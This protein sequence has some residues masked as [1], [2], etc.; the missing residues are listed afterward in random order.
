MSVSWT[1]LRHVFPANFFI[2]PANSP[3]DDDEEEE[4][5]SVLRI[6]LLQRMGSRSFAT[7][8][9]S[10]M[11]DW[12]A[13]TLCKRECTDADIAVTRTGLATAADGTSAISATILYWSS[14]QGWRARRHA[15]DRKIEN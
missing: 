6:I 1:W 7:A 9:R 10:A 15:R 4:E 5:D 12:R 14:S 2:R 3:G 11:R 8:M 13:N